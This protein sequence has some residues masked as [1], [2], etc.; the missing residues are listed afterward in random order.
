M[1]FKVYLKGKSTPVNIIDAE[2]VVPNGD[3]LLFFKTVNGPP[4]AAIPTANV[5]HAVKEKA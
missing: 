4:V 2:R 1:G 3:V 5:S